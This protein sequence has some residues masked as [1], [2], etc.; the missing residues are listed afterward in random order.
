MNPHGLMF[1]HFRNDRHRGGQGAI[2][3]ETFAHLLELIGLDRI[4]PARE[5][6]ARAIDG[7]LNE[8]DLCLTFDDSLLCQFEIAVPVLEHF[9]KTAFWFVYSS[10]FEG[11]VEPF[12]IY[13]HFRTTRY[14]NL[15][16]FYDEFLGVCFDAYPEV[17]RE[18]LER[19]GSSQYLAAFYYYSEADK[20]F[21]FLRDEVLGPGRYHFVMAKILA[22]HKVD[23]KDLSADIWMTNAHLKY[24]HDRDHEI[25]LHSYT[26]P[27]RLS[28]CPVSEQRTE[29]ERNAAHLTQ[30]LGVPP[31]TMSHPN[32][33][34]SVETLN[35][36]RDMG[37]AVGFR[38]DM[39]SVPSRSPL[40]FP[41]QD[42]ADLMRNFGMN[43]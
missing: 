5:W 8:G 16:H 9:N 22:N 40:E 3:A 11:F 7:T 10:V 6:R 37:I 26:H 14:T 38:A 13:R 12:E 20:K 41:R 21:R 31:T 15:D 17:T 18:G 28:N 4:L 34:Y 2:T 24:L 36:L 19:F 35:I 1:H 43:Q 39:A 25:G 23:E 30:L 33:S 32:N 27:T 29:Y 42:H